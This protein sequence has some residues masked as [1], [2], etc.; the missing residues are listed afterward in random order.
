MDHVLG[1]GGFVFWDHNFFD[2]FSV[3]FGVLK[4]S[5][6]LVV[7]TGFEIHP[8]SHVV[9]HNLR[10]HLIFDSCWKKGHWWS[11]SGI[12]IRNQVYTVFLFVI[13]T[14]E[15]WLI[16]SKLGP[17]VFQT[18][19][20]PPNF[21]LVITDVHQGQV[22]RENKSVIIIL[23]PNKD[24]LGL[25]GF[26]S[27]LNLHGQDHSL[28]IPFEFFGAGSIYNICPCL[29]LCDKEGDNLV[30]FDLVEIGRASLT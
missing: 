11:E 23:K 18:I 7:I 13:E 29:R 30:L 21:P 3:L 20:R 27:D 19:L 17:C 9:R 26:G 10:M 8:I 15:F 28:V 12:G 1:H 2:V 5:H 4:A 14:W 25:V 16:Y 22:L 6:S 24:Y